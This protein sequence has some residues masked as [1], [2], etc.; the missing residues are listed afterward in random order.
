MTNYECPRI[1]KKYTLITCSPI[2]ALRAL[3]I[4]DSQ[5][6]PA[7]HMPKRQAGQL[8]AFSRLHSSYSPD[9]YPC[10]VKFSQPSSAYSPRCL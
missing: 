9:Q 6:T 3:E 7:S 4:D 2:R 1:Q 8:T 10:S 5:F